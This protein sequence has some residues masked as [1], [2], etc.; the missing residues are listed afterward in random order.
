MNSVGFEFERMLT[1]VLTL[2]ILATQQQMQL[3]LVH[4][5]SFKTGY[6]T[7]IESTRPTVYQ[8]NS[9]DAHKSLIILLH[10]A[11]AR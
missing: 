10:L 2:R 7:L 8:L 5:R 11:T 9:H 4:L 6:A 3:M 1:F